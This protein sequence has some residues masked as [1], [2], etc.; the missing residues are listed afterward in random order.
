[1]DQ[2]WTKDVSPLHRRMALDF[3][4][5]N[6]ETLLCEGSSTCENAYLDGEEEREEVAD[7]EAP[8]ARANGFGLARLRDRAQAL[9]ELQEGRLGP[10]GALQR[11]EETGV[12]GGER[13]TGGVRPQQARWEDS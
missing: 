13:K 1:M 10:G 8:A 6:C 7:A 3:K 9:D 11:F 5:V 2:R 4:G 12:C